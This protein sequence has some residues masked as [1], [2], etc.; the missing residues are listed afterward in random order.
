M[1]QEQEF[2]THTNIQRETLQQPHRVWISLFFGGSATLIIV[3]LVLGSISLLNPFHVPGA[4]LSRL[5]PLL[6]SLPIILLGAFLA[7]LLFSLL[8]F[9]L[10]RPTGLIRYLRRVHK[11]QQ[12]YHDLYTPLTA[13]TNIRRALDEYEPGIDA[14]T[15]TIQ[16]EQVSILDLV[17]QQDA[18]Q[19][20]L[21]V[22]G[23]GK[24]MALRVYQ[25]SAS[26]QP[27]KLA[28]R[29]KRIP[30][31]VPMKNYS[32]Y[33]KKM[34]PVP[35]SVADDA[36][37]APQVTLL[38]FLYESDLPGMH[39]LRPYVYRLA[40]QGRLLLLCD[41]LNEVDSNYLSQVSQELVALMRTTENR[42]VMTC[43]EVDYREQSEFV[44]LVDEGQAEQ[45]VI[46]PLQPEQI[47]E[48]IETYVTA[49]GNQWRHTAGQIMQVIDRSRLRYHCT[50]PMM[51]FTLMGIIDKIGVERGKQIDT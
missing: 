4:I 19:L 48:F 38:D 43:R 47:Y 10:L 36:S 26:Q 8:A 23:A 42:L 20:I 27:F 30:V 13:L 35:V 44:Q 25:H 2:V 24:T 33:L 34:Q 29:R 15:V 1:L 46:Y 6:S 28:F 3:L 41:G 32:L 50:N 45:V 22:P 5:A 40:Q 7:L 18:H 21:G 39:S 49:Q 51:L 9:F 31:Y 37:E 17:Q 16:E 12:Q 11:D 14:P